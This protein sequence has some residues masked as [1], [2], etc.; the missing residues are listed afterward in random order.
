MAR[1]T[2]WLHQLDPRAKLITTLIFIITVVSVDKYAVAQLVPFMI[3]PFVMIGIGNLPAR[4]L[5]KK[6]C[7]VAPF[8]ILLGIF[9][10]LIDRTIIMHVHTLGIS[11]GWISFAS[12]MI[13]FSLTV[14]AALIL[15]ALTSFNGICFALERFRVPRIFVTQLLFLYRYIFVLLDETCRMAR[16]RALRAFDAKGPRMKT[17]SSMLGYLLLKATSRA[18]RIHLAMCCRGFD[19]TVHVMNAS[20]FGA[21][22]ALFIIGW[23]SLFILF[24]LFNIPEIIGTEILRLQP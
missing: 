17:F 18:E 6:I 16:A 19:G 14:G 7:L 13:R 2:S 9:N 20:R 4:Y 23:S 5:L 3:F 21:R 22:D 8:A 10:P 15:I 11:G 12:L 1:Q 24:R